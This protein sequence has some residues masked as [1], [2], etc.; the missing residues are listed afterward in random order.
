MTRDM[1]RSPKGRNGEAGSTRSARAGAGTASPNPIPSSDLDALMADI[2]VS[3]TYKYMPMSTRLTL[4]KAATAITSLRNQLEEAK[5]VVTEANNSL[6]GSQNFFLSTDGGEPDK[7]HL[8]RPIEDLKRRSTASEARERETGAVVLAIVQL[9][10]EYLPPDGISKDEFIN[11]VL[12]VL[13]NDEMAELVSK[14]EA[15]K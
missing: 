3:V 1:D 2:E 7:Y 9:A 13:D 6:Y 12:G 10:R 8:A 14:L 15:V 5:A 11:R 4:D